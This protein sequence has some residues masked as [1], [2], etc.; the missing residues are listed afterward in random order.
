METGI[1][2][3]GRV[4]KLGQLDQ[5][6]LMNAI[7]NSV[8][9]TVQKFNWAITDVVDQRN[10]PHPY[11][12]GRLSKYTREGQVKLV[13]LDKK[14]Q[15][16]ARAKN[17]LIASSPFVYLPEFSGIAYLRV[18]NDIQ[19]DVFPRRFKRIIEETYNQFFVD[20]SIEAVADYRE[21]VIKLREIDEVKRIRA[22]VHP[23]NPLFGRLWAPLR[24]YLKKR[25]ATEVRVNESSDTGS[26]NTELV[27]LVTETLNEK[28]PEAKN[29]IGLTDAALLMAADGYGNGAVIGKKKGET[30]VI[31]TSDTQTNFPF[32]KD[33]DPL[34]LAEE[35][36][37]RFQRISRERNME[38]P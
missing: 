10:E 11:V 17:L 22:V 21:F 23:P 26:L 33:P 18:W 3:V 32:P 6:T 12:F 28:S 1:Y 8:E 34:A 14:S 24:D 5:T 7:V 30:V 2:F 29:E 16:D 35:T 36:R 13:D 25:N 37:S 19:D 15:V 38:H 9:V 4:I 27:T 20:C 31:H